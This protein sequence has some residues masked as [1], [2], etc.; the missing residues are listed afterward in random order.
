LPR[1]PGAFF[2]VHNE[3]PRSDNSEHVPN[4]VEFECGVPDDSFGKLL[5]E[6]QIL[7]TFGAK[8]STVSCR[9]IKESSK[10]SLISSLIERGLS[11]DSPRLFVLDGSKALSKAVKDA[12]GKDAAIQRCQIHKKTEC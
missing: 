9:F 8:K 1:Y 12:F 3:K 5:L 10:N 2:I 11:V 6:K 7:D 4:F